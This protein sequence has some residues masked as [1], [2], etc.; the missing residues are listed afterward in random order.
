MRTSVHT[1]EIIAVRNKLKETIEVLFPDPSTYAATYIPGDTLVDV[2][3]TLD[4]ELNKL[5][6][7]GEF[8][9][10]SSDPIQHPHTPGIPDGDPTGDIAEHTID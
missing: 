7:I 10:K 2:I 8:W 4:Q 3:T 5:M 9:P 1:S 6:N